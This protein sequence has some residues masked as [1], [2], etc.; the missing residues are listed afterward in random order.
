MFRIPGRIPITIYGTFWL[1]A[2][3]IGFVNSHNILGTLIW[4]A[5]IFVS[6]LFH[7][8][9]HALTALLFGQNPQIELVALGGLTYHDGKTL[10]FWKQ[11]FIVLNGPLFG[12]LLFGI[13]TF[14]LFVPSIAQSS[15]GPILSL[16]RAVNLFW[17]IVN[18]I[19]VMPLDGGQLLRVAFEALF[20]LKGFKYALITGIVIAGL[21]CLASFLYQQFFIGALF[22]LFAFQSY[23]T[24]GRT[25]HLTES[26]RDDNVRDLIARTEQLLQNGQKDQAAQLCEEIRQ[27]AKNGLLFALATQYLAFLK[28]EKGNS[29]ESYQLLL[30]IKE[31]L[32]NDAICLLHQAAFDQ[33][34]FALVIEL[35]SSCF[36]TLPT[37]E[38]ALRN[39]LAHAQLKQ[40][41][42]AVGWLRTAIQEGLVNVE[43]IIKTHSFDLIRQD[44]AFEEFIKDLNKPIA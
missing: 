17:T 43:E 13:A 38:T 16:T 31:D 2:A 37:A 5:I 41:I 36:Q 26:D 25:R 28:Y 7:E 32:A 33:H 24:L 42:P 14:L 18:L 23:T 19:P 15:F 35:G 27:K 20:G 10:P 12:F 21:I 34:D 6:V 30:S 4:M 44:P 40:S 11:F 1:L 9:G 3:L 39:A 29:Q 8:L 22:F